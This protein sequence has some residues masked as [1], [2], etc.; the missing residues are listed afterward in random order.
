MVEMN[1][2]QCESR[3]QWKLVL[4]STMWKPGLELRSSGLTSA[5]THCAIPPADLCAPFFSCKAKV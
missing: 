3:G 4:S 2:L 5:L 1:M